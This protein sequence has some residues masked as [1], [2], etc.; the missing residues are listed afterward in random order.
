MSKSSDKPADVGETLKVA[1]VA[2]YLQVTDRTV[3]RWLSGGLLPAIRIGN[4]TRVRREDLE[5]FLDEHTISRYA[6]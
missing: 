3:Y 6:G 2:A 1:Q 5:Q 4:I